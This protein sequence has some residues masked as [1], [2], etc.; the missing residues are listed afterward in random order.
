MPTVHAIASDPSG[1]SRY[2]QRLAQAQPELLQAA[3]TAIEQPFDIAA[4][5][6]W[7]GQQ[8]AGDEDALKRALRRLRQQVMLRVLLRD[9]SGRAPLAEVV[10][11]MSD[12]AE[13]CLEHALRRLSTWLEAQYGTP[14]ANG[15]RQELI[16]VGMGKLG[17]R[18]LNVS[19]DIDLIFVYPEEGETVRG[20]SDNG[21][22]A[23][24]RLLSNYEYF[25]RLGRKLINA[26]ADVTEDGQ[27]FRVDMRLRPNGDSGP[28]ACSFD[29]LE[30]YF[31]AEGREW[32]RYAWIKARIVATSS[33][34]GV[35]VAGDSGRESAAAGTGCGRAAV[36]V[37]QIPG[38]RR[39]FGDAFAARADPR[40]SRPARSRRTIKLGPGGIREI[41][42]IAQAF[43]LIRGGRDVELQI[44]PTL[45][46]LALLQK[47]ACCPRR[48]WPNSAR[49]TISCAVW[50]IACS[51]W[52]TRRPTNCLPAKMTRPW[53]R[54]PWGLRTTAGSSA[55]WTRCARRCHAISMTCSPHPSETSMPACRFGMGTSTPRR[56]TSGFA[57]WVLPT[58]VPRW[59]ASAARARRNAIRNS[60]SQAVN[61][62]TP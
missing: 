3:L 40:R 43:Q 21:S 31:I 42:F 9:L 59:P 22:S 5:R 25:T 62:T 44:R 8:P 49:P 6:A 7:L 33:K 4:M 35:S 1:Y 45:E 61:A 36:R 20:T 60:R 51:T 34:P 17:G 52:T 39:V 47:K 19:S 11:S 29:A 15:K 37:P 41:E 48:W 32:E 16:V 10:S 38:L 2:A 26:L 50:S 55:G 53:S 23:A 13:L 14:M 57:R 58:P 56:R 54:L 28:L 18:E 30:N 46:V 24:P 12:L 27:V